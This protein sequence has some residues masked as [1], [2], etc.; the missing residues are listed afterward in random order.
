MRNEPTRTQRRELLVEPTECGV[1]MWVHLNELS[2]PGLGYDRRSFLPF[3][4]TRGLISVDVHARECLPVV[5][6]DRNE[7]VVVLATSI[8]AKFI[9]NLV[10]CHCE[11]RFR[12]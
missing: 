8:F 12:K 2:Y 6:V 4:E 11:P 9:D 7:P 3:S 10:I 1:V 5:V